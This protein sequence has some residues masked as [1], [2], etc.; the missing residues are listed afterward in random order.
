MAESKET[1]ISGGQLQTVTIY[2][3]KDKKLSKKENKRNLGQEKRD[4]A[5][6]KKKT[7]ANVNWSAEDRNRSRRKAKWKAVAERYAAGRTNKP[8]A[9]KFNDITDFTVKSEKI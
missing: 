5:K 6:P 3:K 4:A 9:R 7:A 8:V 1:A 2:G